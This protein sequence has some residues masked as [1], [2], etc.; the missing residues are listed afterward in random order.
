MSTAYSP[1]G[2]CPPI[3][4]AGSQLAALFFF[5]TL[6]WPPQAPRPAQGLFLLAP[7]T[8]SP[9]LGRLLQ[10]TL[11]R[12]GACLA[13]SRLLHPP[14]RHLQPPTGLLEGWPSHVSLEGFRASQPKTAD[15]AAGGGVP[16]PLPVASA[17]PRL[18]SHSQFRL[19]GQPASGCIPST[20]FSVAERRTRISPRFSPGYKRF[21]GPRF[22]DVSSLRCTHASDREAH[23]R[24]DPT[25]FS[26]PSLRMGRMKPQLRTR[27]TPVFRHEPA[28]CVSAA[29]FRSYL[30]ALHEFSQTHS[31]HKTQPDLHLTPCST[32]R[33]R[34]ALPRVSTQQ[35]STPIASVA[36][37]PS[38]KSLY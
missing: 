9:R 27:L 35:H 15:D 34:V 17:S 19:P 1:R 24:P 2:V 3:T 21:S 22:L 29:L 4:R 28:A 10:A 20:L 13:V 6:P 23:R 11:R 12:T 25:P 14:C 18:R 7:T 37:A 33:H 36:P 8:V 32:L 26:T 16:A 38:F 30:H 5:P 31:A